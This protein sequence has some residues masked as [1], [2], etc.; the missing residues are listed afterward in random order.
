[1]VTDLGFRSGYHSPRHE[2]GPGSKADPEAGSNRD[3]L[4][5]VL[6]SRRPPMTVPFRIRSMRRQAAGVSDLG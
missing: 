2:P 5:C 1:M 4:A 6:H 3:Q